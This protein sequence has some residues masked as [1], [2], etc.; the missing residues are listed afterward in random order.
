MKPTFKYRIKETPVQV[1][2]DDE[3]VVVKN[4]VLIEG[5]QLCAIYDLDEMW[6]PFVCTLLEDLGHMLATQY[7]SMRESSWEIN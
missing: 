6:F 1:I 7:L 4:G 2:H 5:E 3:G